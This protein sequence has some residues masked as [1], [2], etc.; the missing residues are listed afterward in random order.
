MTHSLALCPSPPH[1]GVL[2]LVQSAMGSTVNLEALKADLARS[3]P[4]KLVEIAV[5]TY[6]HVV[7]YKAFETRP[8]LAD[9]VPADLVIFFS[10]MRHA[11]LRRNAAIRAQLLSIGAEFARAGLT[12]VALKGAGEL[13]A[14]LHPDPAFRFLS[15][16]DVLLHEADLDRAVG[17]LHQ[18]GAVSQPE[19]DINQLGHHHREPLWHPDWPVPVELHRGLGAAAA[20]GILPATEVLDAARPTDAA[21]LAVPSQVHRLAHAVLHAQIEPPRFREA[22]LSLR[23]LVE[24]EVMVRRLEAP[25]IAKAREIID[26]GGA[27]D[28]WNALDAARML[29]LGGAPGDAPSPLA[30]RIWAERALARF[31]QPRRRRRKLFIDLSQYYARAILFHPERRR[32][33]L[34]QLLRPGGLAKALAYQRDKFRRTR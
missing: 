6:V 12:G 5:S 10:E 2:G 25:R 9:A 34:R 17:V 27:R 18:A 20:R 23:D 8:E 11:N 30:A 16:I 1:R 14:P 21:G 3:D 26:A 29:L 22:T 32:H 31:G 15:D 4:E 28:A 13:L 7:L 33:Y 19:A 24:M